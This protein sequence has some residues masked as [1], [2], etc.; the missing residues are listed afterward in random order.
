MCFLMLFYRNLFL[1]NIQAEIS[2]N[3]NRSVRYIFLCNITLLQNMFYF[4]CIYKRA[5]NQT[6]NLIHII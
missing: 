2:N 5:E 6:Q 1:I 4:L 3:Q